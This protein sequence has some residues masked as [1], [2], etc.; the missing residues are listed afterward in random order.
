MN[1]KVWVAELR[2]TMKSLKTE[3]KAAKQRDKPFC[4]WE[5]QELA[6]VMRVHADKLV[7]M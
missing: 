2:R 3:V 5:R 7:R 4:D 1:R 6:R